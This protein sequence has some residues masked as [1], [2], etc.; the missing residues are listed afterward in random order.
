MAVKFEFKKVAQLL[1]FSFFLLPVKDNGKQTQE[2]HKLMELASETKQHD[3]HF[4][5]M[6]DVS[7]LLSRKIGFLPLPLAPPKR[8]KQLLKYTCFRAVRSK[9]LSRYQNDSPV[10][11]L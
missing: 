8:E 5:K 4:G 7:P 6:K 3:A 10:S 9:A 1:P 11:L 2:C